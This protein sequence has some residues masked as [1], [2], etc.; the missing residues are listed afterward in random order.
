MLVPQWQVNMH[1]RDCKRNA[2]AA[3]F[4]FARG[5]PLQIADAWTNY[6]PQSFDNDVMM[7]EQNPEQEAASSVKPSPILEIWLHFFKRKSKK[8]TIYMMNTEIYIFKTNFISNLQSIL[9]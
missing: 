6:K 9:K 1:G 8:D 7:V 2:A 5:A 3:L 4:L